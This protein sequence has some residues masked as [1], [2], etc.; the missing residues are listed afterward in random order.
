MKINYKL[1]KKLIF[2]IDGKKV[3]L[4]EFLFNRA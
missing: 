4:I 3:N 2:H 1:A